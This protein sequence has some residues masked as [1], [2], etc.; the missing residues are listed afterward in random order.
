MLKPHSAPQLS[1]E[2]ASPKGPLSGGYAEQYSRQKK[3]PY[4]KAYTID[5]YRRLT[6]EKMTL[7]TLGPDLESDSHRERVS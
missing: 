6:K 5:D 7:G 2:L 3:K 1:N 4:F